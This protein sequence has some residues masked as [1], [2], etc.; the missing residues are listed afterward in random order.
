[1]FKKKDKND[2]EVRGGEAPGTGLSQDVVT[3]TLPTG[4]GQV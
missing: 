4:R 2:R 1:V 3:S